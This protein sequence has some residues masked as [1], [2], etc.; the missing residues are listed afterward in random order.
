M[1]FLLFVNTKKGNLTKLYSRTAAITEWEKSHHTTKQYALK[2][3]LSQ[4][5][6]M[7]TVSIQRSSLTSIRKRLSELG[8]PSSTV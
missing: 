8:V 6:T 3:A 7:F 4:H 2:V 1:V 5:N